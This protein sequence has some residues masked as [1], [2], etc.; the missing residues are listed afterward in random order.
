MPVH[1]TADIAC[2]G[3]RR[4]ADVPSRFAERA[5]AAADSD[6][7]SFTRP[8]R[9]L[10]GPPGRA[11]QI[12]GMAL[13]AQSPPLLWTTVAAS[14]VLCALAVARHRYAV[15]KGL[16]EA[17]PDEDAAEQTDLERLEKLGKG[18]GKGFPV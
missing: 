11:W 7:R 3:S 5:P 8:S 4:I 18:F 13:L 17:E 16:E 9:L 15:A 6:R 1:E 12:E 2:P 10:H 14:G